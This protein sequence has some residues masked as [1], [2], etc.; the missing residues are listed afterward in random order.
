MTPI[1]LDLDESLPISIGT[2]WELPI[3]W[4]QSLYAA[5]NKALQVKVGPTAD[6]NG[7]LCTAV[8]T[9]G[10]VTLPADTEAMLGGTLVLTKAQTLLLSAG[11]VFYWVSMTEVGA[12]PLPWM[13]GTN[14]AQPWGE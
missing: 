3:R 4:K 10:V 14:L 5:T 9:I 11:S 7:I 6:S 12:D 1:V 13:S 2:E 8:A